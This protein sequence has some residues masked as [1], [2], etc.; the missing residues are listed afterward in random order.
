MNDLRQCVVLYHDPGRHFARRSCG[1]RPTWGRQAKGAARGWAAHAGYRLA[2]GIGRRRLFA[3]FSPDMQH[4]D[5]L[6]WVRT[7]RAFYALEEM[8]LPYEMD[9]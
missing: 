2:A 1:H 9:D 3:L 8:M 6:L 7:I 4:P 5:Q